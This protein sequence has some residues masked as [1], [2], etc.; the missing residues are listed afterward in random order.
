MEYALNAKPLKKNIPESRY[1][2]KAWKLVNLKY[3]E[4]FMLVLI[5]L[6]TVC[7]AVQVR[8]YRVLQEFCSCVLEI[9]DFKIKFYMKNA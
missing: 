4:Y 2:L 7:L 6:N 1:R 9:R 5:L 3:F 8:F